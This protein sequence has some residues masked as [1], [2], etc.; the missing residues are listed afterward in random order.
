MSDEWEENPGNDS[1]EAN[2]EDT[3]GAELEDPLD[4]FEDWGGGELEAAYLK[5]LS[6]LEA[7]ETEIPALPDHVINMTDDPSEAPASPAISASIETRSE[8]RNPQSVPVHSQ[9]G[10]LLTS[11]E[12][13][14][15]PTRSNPPVARIETV[16]V[17]ERPPTPRQI[18]EACLFVGGAALTSK[19]LSGILRGEFDTDYVDR[20]IDELNRLYAAENRPYE[21]RMGEGG[22]RLTLRDDF[23]R[24]RHKVYGLGPKEVRLSQEALEVLAVVAY[25]QPIKQSRVEE[26][27]KPGCGPVLRQLVRRELIAVERDPA[28]PRDVNYKTTARFLSLFD[29]RSLDE[30]PRHEQVSYK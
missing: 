7:S 22:D 14:P 26:L 30:L 28:H 27:G 4:R 3:E 16:T 17:S 25:H 6:A 20:E 12:P 21:I 18:I 19:R 23:E 10:S 1:F 29:I 9:D 8:E 24:I 2:S 13:L 11:A 5:A 15:S